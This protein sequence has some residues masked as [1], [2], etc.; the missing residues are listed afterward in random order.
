MYITLGSQVMPEWLLEYEE[1]PTSLN[2]ERKAHWSARYKKS[3]EWR[4]IFAT[5]AMAKG[6]PELSQI[7]VDIY[8]EQRGNGKLQDVGNCYPSAKA[9]ID[10]LV[11]AGVIPDD[12]P[13]HLLAIKFFAPTRSNRNCLRMI[14][15]N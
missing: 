9:A 4:E 11:D 6:I 10:G 7:C 5:L 14:V 2:A 15:R 1:R 3:A 12:T 8:V 13:E